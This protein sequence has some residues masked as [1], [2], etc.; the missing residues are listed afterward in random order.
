MT[1]ENVSFMEMQIEENHEKLATAVSTEKVDLKTVYGVLRPVLK[2]LA[3][4]GWFLGQKTREGIRL[5][6][7]VMDAETGYEKVE[8]LP[9]AFKKK[10]PKEK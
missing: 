7:S 1:K 5:F 6:I 8:P 2:G 4:W 3:D 10:T 9:K